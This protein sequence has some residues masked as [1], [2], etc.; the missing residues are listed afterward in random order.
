MVWNLDSL[1]STVLCL[2]QQP[3]LP[4]CNRPL[5]R[6]WCYFGMVV[7]HCGDYC[8]NN[9]TSLSKAGLKTQSLYRLCNSVLFPI[10]PLSHSSFR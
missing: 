10:P 4:E 9:C 5:S 1:E 3:I 6:F 7:N 8:N 2:L